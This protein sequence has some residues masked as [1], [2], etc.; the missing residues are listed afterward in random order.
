MILK[1]ERIERKRKAGIWA[2]FTFI[3]HCER[4]RSNPVDDSGKNAMETI[5]LSGNH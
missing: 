4:T 3:R 5:S 2:R 1:D